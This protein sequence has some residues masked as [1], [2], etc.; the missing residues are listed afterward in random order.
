MSLTS[1]PSICTNGRGMA[2]R[3]ICASFRGTSVFIRISVCG[4]ASGVSSRCWRFLTIGCSISNIYGDRTCHCCH[5][6]IPAAASRYAFRC[7]TFLVTVLDRTADTLIVAIRDSWAAYRVHTKPC[8]RSVS[9]ICVPGLIRTRLKAHG[10]M[11][12]FPQSL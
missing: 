9:L 11:F 2:S 4:K 6:H 5:F 10:A 7:A 3:F 1:P 8:T 12:D